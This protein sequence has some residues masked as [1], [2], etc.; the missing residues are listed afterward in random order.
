MPEKTR[1]YQKYRRF[2]VDVSHY[3]QKKQFQVYTGIIM[4]VVA[5]IFF[6]VF[7]I[8]PTV[9]TISNLVSEIKTQRKVAQQLQNKIN[10][11]S[12]AQSNYQQIKP[13]LPLINETLPNSTDFPKLIRQIEA[14]GRKNNV[15]VK[16]IQF[17]N[18]S[19]IG[20]GEAVEGLTQTK[21]K[22]VQAFDFNFTAA[23]QYHELKS[24]LEDLNSLQRLVL[25]NNYLIQTSKREAG[26]VLSLEAKACYFEK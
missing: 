24:F 16:S 7:A 21:T 2:F 17:D 25:V 5:V 12:L 14:L 19:L 4:S 8:R 18:V 22:D 3:Y 15:V 11:L 13:K 10:S 9:L 26:L 1:S 23:G 20:E 6:L